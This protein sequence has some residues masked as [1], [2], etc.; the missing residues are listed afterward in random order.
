M[1]TKPIYTI[2][3]RFA[4]CVAGLAIVAANPAHAADDG[5]ASPATQPAKRPKI[6]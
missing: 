2:L 5:I 4:G 3:G 6:V 1:N